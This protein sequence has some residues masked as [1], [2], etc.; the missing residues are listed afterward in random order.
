VATPAT[1]HF[2]NLRA[3][4]DFVLIPRA[5]SPLRLCAFARNPRAPSPRSIPICSPS[6]IG[7]QERL[8]ETV[9]FEPRM[10]TERCPEL[11]HV[12][13]DRVRA[14]V[15]LLRDLVVRHETTMDP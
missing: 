2:K 9:Q 13:S 1:T 5:P 15:D 6:V 10:D 3:L 14:A 12:G 7:S 8:D 11:C 4:R